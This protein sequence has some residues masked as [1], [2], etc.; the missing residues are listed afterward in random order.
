MVLPLIELALVLLV[1][2]LLGVGAWAYWRAWVGPR[3]ARE[4]GSALVLPGAA[5]AELAAAIAAARWA[6]AHDEVDGATRVLVRKSYT[7]LDG[8]PEVLEERVITSFP[9]SDPE[10]EVRFIEGM[11]QARFRCTYLNAEE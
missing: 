5:R 7:G 11:S 6:P 1:V 8:R 2:G 3:P 10:W 9:S 4:L